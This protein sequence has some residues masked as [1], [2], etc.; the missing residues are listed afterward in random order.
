[1]SPTF[2]AMVFLIASILTIAVVMLRRW[3]ESGV[4]SDKSRGNILCLV[5]VCLIEMFNDRRLPTATAV[6]GS[7]KIPSQEHVK[8]GVYLSSP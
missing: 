2:S 8:H 4:L 6:I 7:L 3:L 5:K 1:M